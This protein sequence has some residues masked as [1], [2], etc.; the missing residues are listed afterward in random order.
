MESSLNA[1]QIRDC[2]HVNGRTT[3]EGRYIA[4]GDAHRSIGAKKPSMEVS[5]A[6]VVAPPGSL[7]CAFTCGPCEPVRPCAGGVCSICD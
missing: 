1:S 7:N 3:T 6:N 5:S 2:L 4:R